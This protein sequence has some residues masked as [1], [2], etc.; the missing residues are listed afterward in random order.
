M[1]HILTPRD[2][3]INTLFTFSQCDNCANFNLNW[4]KELVDRICLKSNKLLAGSNKHFSVLII[5]GKPK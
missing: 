3:R 2:K 5:E 4:E 1:C